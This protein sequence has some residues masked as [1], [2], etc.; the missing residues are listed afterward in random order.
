MRQIKFR[1]RTRNGN[2][3]Y[4]DLIQSWNEASIFDGERRCRVLDDSVAQFVGCDKTGVEVYEGDT[5]VDE[6]EN[7]FVAEIYMRPEQV[8]RLTLKS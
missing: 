1:G 3:V 7:E 4:G 2:F 5:L 8:A 6:L